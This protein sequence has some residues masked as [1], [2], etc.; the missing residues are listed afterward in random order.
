[1]QYLLVLIGVGIIIL[2]ARVIFNKTLKDFDLINS[3]WIFVFVI[4]VAIVSYL[5]NYNGG[6]KII[7]FGWDLVIIALLSLVV[8]ALAFVFRLDKNKVD[9]Y[10]EELQMLE[11]I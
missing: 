4:G 8:F 11:N 7:P 6:K 5:G 2:F 3:L 1:M 10:R 9:S